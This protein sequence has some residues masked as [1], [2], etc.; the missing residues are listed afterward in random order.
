MR[1][2]DRPPRPAGQPVALRPLSPGQQGILLQHNAAPGSP[3]FNVPAALELT[4]PL[5]EHALRRALT[6]LVAR[7]E[8]LRTTFP[9]HATGVAQAIHPPHEAALPVRDLG[10]VPAAEQAQAARELLDNEAA[11][12]FDLEHETG[13]RCRLVRLDTERHVLFWMMHHIICD[14]WSKAVFATDLSALYAAHHAGTPVPLPELSVSYSDFAAEQCDTDPAVLEQ[15]LLYWDKQLEGVADLP[16]LVAAHRA[17]ENPARGDSIS[18]TI[19]AETTGRLHAVGR[20]GRS[21][22]F[23][24]LHAALAVALQQGS[25]HRDLLINTPYG[26]RPSPAF[27]PLIGFFVNV[28]ALR[29][30]LEGDPAFRELLAQVRGTALDAYEHSQAPIQHVA[31]RLAQRNR[32]RVGP[33][34]EISLAFANLPYQDVRLMGLTVQGFPL[35]RV[36]VRYPLELHLWEDTASPGLGGRLIFRT[37]LVD[38]DTAAA[39]VDAYQKVLHAVAADPGQ[40]LSQLAPLNSRFLEPPT[41]W[42]AAGPLDQPQAWA[43]PSTDTERALLDIWAG[44]LHTDDISATDSFVDLGGHSLLV[45]LMVA[46]VRDTFGVDLPVPTIYQDPTL[47]SVASAIDAAAAT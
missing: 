44:L 20:Q 7:H 23:M 3:I 38:R 34:N 32:G 14:G 43:E 8:V 10:S 1:V 25:G 33:L 28:L 15:H 41:A 6:D 2:E 21:S 29:T 46:K 17:G 31:H 40:R 22:L 35:T 16:T 4:G 13:L 24:V 18:L 30:R 42:Q 27:E 11:I 37:D 19:D 39:L 26:G 45:A 47:R 5:D 9:Q 36:D 12:P